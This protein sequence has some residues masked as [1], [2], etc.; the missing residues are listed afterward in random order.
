MR[1]APKNKFVCSW[2]PIIEK[3]AASNKTS[4]HLIVFQV[5]LEPRKC[6]AQRLP[7]SFLIFL[8][9]SVIVL[10]RTNSSGNWS[11]IQSPLFYN[12]KP[13]KK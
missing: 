7:K 5:G 12:F 3:K 11:E 6:I 1:E 10:N 8:T 9:I 2:F 4:L 13:L